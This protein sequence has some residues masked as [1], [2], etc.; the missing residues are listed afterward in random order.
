LLPEPEEAGPD[1]SQSDDGSQLERV[2]A[3]RAAS[4]V[5]V[6]ELSEDLEA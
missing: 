3:A 2:P 5:D 1:D 4:G 6:R